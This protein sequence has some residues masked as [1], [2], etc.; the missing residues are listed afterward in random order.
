MIHKENKELIQELERSNFPTSKVRSIFRTED[1]LKMNLNDIKNE[2]RP[3][4][5]KLKIDE[6]EGLGKEPSKDNLN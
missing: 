3:S 2:A 5:R 1:I 6:K 4:G